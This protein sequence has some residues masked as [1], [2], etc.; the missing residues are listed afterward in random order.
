M[1]LK[2][3]LNSGHEDVPGAKILVCVSSVGPRKI[4]K[5][6]NAMA[7]VR[8][9]D[10]TESNCVLKVWEDKVP[11]AKGWI[12]NQTILL[13]TNPR[14]R[15]PDKKNATSELSI[16][17]TSMIEVDPI[18]S[19][20]TWLRNMASNRT[21]RSV[22]VPFPDGLWDVETAING[23]QRIIFTL[24][25][26][27]DFARD[28]DNSLFTGKLNL[29]IM[30]VHIAENWRRGMMCLVAAVCLFTPTRRLLSARTAARDIPSH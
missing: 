23:D 30:S 26:V 25:D 5:S 11:S 6:G 7:E 21:K 1:S 29:V 10:E 9:F 28:D 20:A 3:Y 2:A 13:I 17:I 22:C 27:D 12:P 8:V 16:G 18:C 14:C 19:D 15:L 24:A 4:V